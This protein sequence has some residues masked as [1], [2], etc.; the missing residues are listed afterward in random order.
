MATKKKTQKNGEVVEARGT[1]SGVVK[2]KLAERHFTHWLQ[3]PYIR[4]D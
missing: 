1:S 3:V 2:T 4:Y